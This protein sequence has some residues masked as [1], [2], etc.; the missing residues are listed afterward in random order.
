MNLINQVLADL[1]RRLKH[2]PTEQ[3]LLSEVVPVAPKPQTRPWVVYG[4]LAIVAIM[5]VYFWRENSARP[6]TQIVTPKPVPVVAVAEPPPSVPAQD[7]ALPA[8]PAALDSASPTQVSASPVATSAELPAEAGRTLPAIDAPQTVTAPVSKVHEQAPPKKTLSPMQQADQ[9]YHRAL[10]QA[11]SQQ[12]GQAI[13]ELQ[14]ILSIRPDHHASRLLLSQLMLL[15]GQAQ[16]ADEELSRGLQ[17]YP[18]NDELRVALARLEVHLGRPARALEILDAGANATRPGIYRALHAVLLQS[19]GQHS[20]AIE[21]YVTALREQPQNASLLVG[22]GVS[23][24]ALGRVSAAQETFSLARNS[25]GLT[26][27]LEEVMRRYSA[28]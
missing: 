24:H 13:R 12:T 19:Q 8:A 20:R 7:I 5:A 26:P 18:D 16:Q 22:L 28:P 4:G 11:R 3:G 10:E 25:A 21:E 6:Q 27:Q 9:Q 23:L 15:Q 1:D 14:A 2:N 17:Q